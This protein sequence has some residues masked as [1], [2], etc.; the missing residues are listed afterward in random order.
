[1]IIGKQGYTLYNIPLHRY[2]EGRGGIEAGYPRD[3]RNW[4]GVPPHIDG[5]IT[6]RDGEIFNIIFTINNDYAGL[7]YFFQAG[8]YWRFN[9]HLVITD[10]EVPA[11]M[12]SEVPAD[13]DSE[14][15]ADTDSEV[16]ADTAHH[17]FGC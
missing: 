16:P 4:R 6:W 10:S 11:D 9:D 1:M 2:D 15:P 5:A 14:V 13:T 12:D 17:W 3:M 7:T 8:Q